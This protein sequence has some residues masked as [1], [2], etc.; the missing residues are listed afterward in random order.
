MCGYWFVIVK[1]VTIA[2]GAYCN[3]K[4]QDSA[5]LCRQ[6]VGAMK[7]DAPSTNSNV[8]LQLSIRQECIAS[9]FLFCTKHFACCQKEAT[10]Q[11]V[12]DTSGHRYNPPHFLASPSIGTLYQLVS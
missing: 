6:S 4:L 11:F 8:D 12:L 3:C 2:V 1:P 9:I 5:Y 7:N 10:I